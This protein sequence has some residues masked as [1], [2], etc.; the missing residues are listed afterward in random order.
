MYVTVGDAL[1]HLYVGSAHP[2][3]GPCSETNALLISYTPGDRRFFDVNFD[4]SIIFSPFLEAFVAL[5]LSTI[6]L[7]TTFVDFVLATP[8]AEAVIH[9]T[10]PS[11]DFRRKSINRRRARKR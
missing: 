3:P 6:R 7:Q 5:D 10:A 8:A 2:T 11:R 4:N 9:W 1:P